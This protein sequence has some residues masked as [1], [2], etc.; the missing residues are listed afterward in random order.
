MA[1]SPAECKLEEGNTVEIKTKGIK[2]YF[3]LKSEVLHKKN[4][5]A[6]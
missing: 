2:F 1:V 6:M 3:F 4:A 5:V